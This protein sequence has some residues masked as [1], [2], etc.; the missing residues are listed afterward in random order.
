MKCSKCGNKTTWDESFGEEHRLICP[1]CFDKLLKKNNND[2]MKTL[3][4][5]FK[6]LLTNQLL[7]DIMQVQ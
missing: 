4:E 5:I 6:N 7:Y 2:V 1:T 3:K